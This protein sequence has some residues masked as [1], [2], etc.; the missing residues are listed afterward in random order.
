MKQ[1][2]LGGRMLDIGDQMR[3]DFEK[4]R[5][6]TLKRERQWFTEEELSCVEN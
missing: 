6:E 3:R 5:L 4:L 1:V 2:Y